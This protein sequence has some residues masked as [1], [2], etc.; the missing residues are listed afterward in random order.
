ML[1]WEAIMNAQ[2][3]YLFQICFK[4]NNSEIEFIFIIFNGTFTFKLKN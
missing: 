4:T 3:K 2:E 1:Y